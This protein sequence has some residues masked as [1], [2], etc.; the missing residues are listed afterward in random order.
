MYKIMKTIYNSTLI[1][2][3]GHI[4]SYWKRNTRV[5]RA[6]EIRRRNES[7]TTKTLEGDI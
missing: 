2:R 3:T 4:A 1:I 7:V 5:R 6:Q